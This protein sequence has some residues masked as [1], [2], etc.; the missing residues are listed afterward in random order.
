MQAFSTTRT[1]STP[2]QHLLPQAQQDQQQLHHQQLLPRVNLQ[3]HPLF[4]I[5]RCLKLHQLH[6][7]CDFRSIGRDH[8][9]CLSNACTSLLIGRLRVQNTHLMV[10]S[11]S[12][13]LLFVVEP[14]GYP[15][16]CIFVWLYVA[17]VQVTAPVAKRPSKCHRRHCTDLNLLPFLGKTIRCG[18]FPKKVPFNQ[19]HS[20]SSTNLSN[21]IM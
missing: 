16:L 4:V 10:T 11:S 18:N 20:M 14:F 1:W 13:F 6:R 15:L 21:K 3:Q 12:T 7:L 17:R 8:E 2:K 9:C 5:I 19:L